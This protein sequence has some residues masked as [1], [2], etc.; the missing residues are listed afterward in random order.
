MKIV[1]DY[2]HHL[3]KQVSSGKTIAR[4]KEHLIKLID[5]QIKKNGNECDLNHIDVSHIKDMSNLFKNSNFNGKISEWDVKNVENMQGMFYWSRFN[6]DIS[7][8]NV[9]KVKN[10]EGMFTESKFNND[11][12]NWNVSDLENMAGM[13]SS[14]KFNKDI[15]K[16]NISNVCILDT[17]FVNSEF[18]GDISDWKPYELGSVEDAFKY[19]KCPIPYWANYENKEDRIKAIN[20]FELNKE[21][22]KSLEVKESKPIKRIKL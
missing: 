17:L 16:W 20:K 3:I 15:S 21:L 9:S 11:I 22:E 13:F 12:S 18:T 2:I 4:N 8:W 1:K 19:S 14:S 10:M 6:G 7:T 5:K